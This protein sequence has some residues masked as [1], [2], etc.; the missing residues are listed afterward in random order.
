[1]VVTNMKW[2][3]VK[4]WVGCPVFRY[5]RL[6]NLTWCPVFRAVAKCRHIVAHFASQVPP[7]NLIFKSE[8]RRTCCHKLS[9]LPGPHC[10]RPHY[11]VLLLVTLWPVSPATSNCGNWHQK[12]YFTWFHFV[13]Q[14]R[15]HHLFHFSV[16]L[17]SHR[18]RPSVWL[19]E[20]Q[21]PTLCF[22]LALGRKAGTGE[23]HWGEK[24]AQRWDERLAR[25]T[26]FSSAQRPVIDWGTPVTGLWDGMDGVKLMGSWQIG[27][28]WCP[29]FPPLP[30]SPVWRGAQYWGKNGPKK[31][32]TACD[33]FDKC[34]WNFPDAIFDNLLENQMFWPQF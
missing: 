33:P 28:S 20:C 31:P 15:P 4:S 30:P 26:F 27:T 1:M 24:L 22:K 12:S 34:V 25:P 3:K 17:C 2:D 32:V 10:T 11:L 5:H 18:S 21:F 23:K 7:V 13:V 29:P 8:G 14:L 19:T 6:E 16:Q 9:R